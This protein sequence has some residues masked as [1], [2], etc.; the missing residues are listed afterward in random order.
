MT[1]ETILVVEDEEL[2]LDS[3]KSLI[4]AEGFRVLTARDGIEAIET[5]EKHREDVGLVLADLGLPR[6]GGWEAL[7]RMRKLKP[8][9]RAI[10]ASGTLDL[11]QRAEMRR[12]G[13]QTTIRKP[14]TAAE[15]LG[16]IRQ[17]LRPLG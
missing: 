4:E 6:L 15:M 1:S 3:L 2:L 16:A 12:S 9:I 10:V 13:V 14:Y 7:A 11:S 5:F 8:E 17:A